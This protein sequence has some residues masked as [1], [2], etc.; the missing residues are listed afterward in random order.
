MKPEITNKLS[1]MN[2]E[3]LHDFVTWLNGQVEHLSSSITVAHN[4]KNF[5]REAQCEGMRDAFMR[6]INKLTRE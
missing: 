1:S 2:P 5:G 3:K 6:C 4:T